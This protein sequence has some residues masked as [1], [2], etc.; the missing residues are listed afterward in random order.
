MGLKR[1]VHACRQTSDGPQA[2][3]STDGRRGEIPGR[4][5]LGRCVL[6]AHP[7]GRR[8]D[9]C[10]DMYYGSPRRSRL[11]LPTS[12]VSKHLLGIGL[13]GLAFIPWGL[14]GRVHAVWWDFQDP[15]NMRA[16]GV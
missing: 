15:W 1:L 12:Q 11:R 14:H 5:W 3:T 7:F 2:T 6:D 8:E 9:R 13:T 16:L 4:R 10:E